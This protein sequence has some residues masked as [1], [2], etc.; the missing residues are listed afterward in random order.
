MKKIKRLL[1]AVLILLLTA[2]LVLTV[3]AI[4][5]DQSYAY[6]YDYMKNALP[7]PTPYETRL[8]LDPADYGAGKL[9]AP[10]G[11]FVHGN[12]LY[13]ADTGNNRILQF[14][15]SGDELSFTR[16]IAKG[17]GWELLA[18]EDLFVDEDGILYIADTGNRRILKLD[19]TLKI[20]GEVTC[21][22]DVAYDAGR[23]FKP[24]KLVLTAGGRIYA[25]V[26]GV[27]KG[28][29]EFNADGSFSGYLGASKVSFDFIDYIWKL[30]STEAQR[31]QMEAFVPTEYNNVAL[32][33]DGFLFVTTDT[34]DVNELAAGNIEVIRRLNLKGTNILIENDEPVIGDYDWDLDVGPSRFIDVTVLEN[35]VYYVL[36][37]AK[38]RIF[39]YDNQGGSL[40][41]FGGYGTR[42][43]YFQTPTALE[44]MDHDLLVLDSTSGFVTF[45]RETE[46][47][48][49]VSSAIENY[50]S[51]HYDEALSDWQEVLRQN[52]NYRFAYDGIGKIMLRRGDYSEALSYLKY[53]RDKYYYSKAW[54]LYRKDWIEHNLIYFVLALLVLVVTLLV[55]K[56]VRKEK[57]ALSDY[58]ERLRIIQDR[59][60]PEHSE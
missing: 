34:F 45:L 24:Q 60:N 56:I 40:Y 3:T 47:G 52:G 42:S 23:E 35:D 50:N 2:A 17:S 53:A 25:Q 7:C 12:D 1:S 51:G 32:D 37:S 36:D 41:V 54:K 31:K 39:A 6:N 49:S 57:E 55:V 15:V 26:K 59:E 11:L 21:P 20:L 33:N 38:N 58:E 18:P 29:V 43:G 16:E 5:E 22:D 30:I 13:I 19:S 27:N 10:Q 9:N 48:H 44:H 14:A 46:Y 4:G 28:L 8:Q